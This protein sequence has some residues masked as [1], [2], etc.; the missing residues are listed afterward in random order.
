M[1][2]PPRR[3]GRARLLG[4]SLP[5][6]FGSKVVQIEFSSGSSSWSMPAFGVVLER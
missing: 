1:F 4:A 6:S 5:I 3:A 2:K